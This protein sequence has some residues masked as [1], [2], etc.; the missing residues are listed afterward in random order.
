MQPLPDESSFKRFC[1]GG[2]RT[3]ERLRDVIT[4]NTDG[5]ILNI[6]ILNFA[7]SPSGNWATPT[8]QR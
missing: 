1:L 6:Q 7:R 2:K 3:V 4:S 8:E 5:A